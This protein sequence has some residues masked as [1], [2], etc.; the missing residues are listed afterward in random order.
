[1]NNSTV[2]HFVLCYC[3]AWQIADKVIF[4]I[5]PAPSSRWMWSVSHLTYSKDAGM[6]L[7]V[8]CSNYISCMK[9]LY[10]MGGEILH[11]YFP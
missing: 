4:M 2:C 5:F 10:S 1:M 8:K 7:S 11:N 3:V 9:G 6:E